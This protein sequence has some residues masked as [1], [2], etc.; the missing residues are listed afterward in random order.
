MIS[1]NTEAIPMKLCSAIVVHM[2]YQSTEGNFQKSDL[3][4][5]NDVIAKNH[6]KVWTSAKRSKKL[7]FTWF[8]I[9]L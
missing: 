1:G 8:R 2:A 6:G 9:K 5:H 7:N 4:R 3:L